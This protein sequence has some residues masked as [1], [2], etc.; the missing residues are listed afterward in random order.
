[1]LKAEK[2]RLLILIFI[3]SLISLTIIMINGISYDLNIKIND[4][5]KGIEDIDIA[6]DPD[7]VIKIVHKKYSNGILKLKIK[8]NHKGISFVEVSSKKHYSI[9]KVFVHEFG[10]ITLNRRLGK[11]NG[12]IVVPISILII[13]I[14]LLSV[15]IK[16]YKKNSEYCLYQ[17]N[18]IITLILGFLGMSISE[19]LFSRDSDDIS[20]KNDS[21][22]Y[23]LSIS[24]SL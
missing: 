10:I 9:N 17:Y 8:S 15:K 13:I 23:C 21:I 18:N 7:N 3:L 22:I 19:L 2:I 12:D 24:R 6:T 1:M 16:H 14:Y 20:K 4:N 5:V 11:C